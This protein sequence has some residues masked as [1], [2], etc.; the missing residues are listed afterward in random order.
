MAKIYGFTFIRNGVHFDYPFRECF[1]C[2]TEL[3]DKIYLAHG[4]D[5]DG[6]GDVIAEY[7]K[8]VVEKTKW[9]MSLMGQ[10]GILLSQQTNVALENLRKAH[11]NEEGAWGIYLQCDE[12]IHENQFEQLK[13]DID[14]AERTGCDALR[15]RYLHYWESHYKVAVN[16]RWYPVEIRAVK[17]NSKTKSCGDAQGF[18]GQTK[19]FDS[20]VYI[21]HYGHVRNEDSRKEKQEFL[22]RSIRAAEK[23]QKYFKREQKA[24]A[25]TKTLSILL[26]HPSAMKGRI[27]SMGEN[28]NLPEK[29]TLYIVGNKESFSNDIIQKINA[30]NIFWVNQLSEVPSEH[31]KSAVILNPNFWQRIFYPS[32]VPPSMESPLARKWDKETFLLLK[33]SE[34]G[35]SFK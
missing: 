9:D 16:K 25:G 21:H 12:L 3:T 19:V 30:K 23:F 18:E 11:G 22:L 7:P 5:E 26:N 6:T 15:F 14:E 32:Q 34:K 20:D 2:L 27:E 29:E 35:V 17:L 24:F 13:K 4:D 10:G 28:F 33:L 1:D 8:M 31:K